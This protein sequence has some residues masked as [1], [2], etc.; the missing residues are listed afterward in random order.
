MADPA[1][2]PLRRFLDPSAW[3]PARRA[4]LWVLAA[5]VVGLVLSMLAIRGGD[6]SKLFRAGGIPPTAVERDYPPLPAPLPAGEGIGLRPPPS[7]QVAD[8][9]A[10]EP[11][12]R[13]PAPV[14]APKPVEAPKPQPVAATRARPIPGRTPAPT[15]PARALR[16]GVGGTTLV[17]VDIGPDGVPTSVAV[18]QSSGSRDLDRAAMQAVRRWRFEPATQDGHPTVG[19]VAIPIDFRPED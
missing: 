12:E 13:K 17:L 9:P 4:W 18:A 7:A 8:A 19:Q 5:V 2:M 6:R 14:K 3:R 1:P 10:P 11:V 15:Y 16:S